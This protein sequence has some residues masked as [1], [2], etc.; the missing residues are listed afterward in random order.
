MV[1]TTDFKD[2]WTCSCGVTNATQDIR[3]VK[4]DGR[5]YRICQSCSCTTDV[6]IPAHTQVLSYKN[7]SKC[8]SSGCNCTNYQAVRGI[9][10]HCGHLGSYHMSNNVPDKT[11]QVNDR[12]KKSEL[13]ESGL[14]F[15]VNSV[16]D[17]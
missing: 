9:E 16:D 4:S 11:V 8:C 7:I 6:Y 1:Q 5:I 3:T 10:C 13:K 2:Q 17:L 12:V 14:S 15:D